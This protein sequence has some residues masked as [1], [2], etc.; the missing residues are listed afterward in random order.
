MCDMKDPKFLIGV[1]EGFYGRPWT[2]EQRRELFGRLNKHG[3]N[4]FV[5]APK[6]DC[7]HRAFWRELY[8]VE[9]AENLMGLV[10]AAKESKI[11]FYYSLSPGLDITYSSE[12]ELVALKRKLDQVLQFGCNAVALLFD[13]IEPEM[14]KKDKEVFQS[15]AHAQV[16]ITNEIFHH[17]KINKFLFC[18]T[19]YCSSR[20]TPD[21]INSEYLS[22]L[23]SQLDPGIDILWTGTKVI[24]KELTIECIQE[25]A[26]VLKRKPLI[27]DNIFA[28]DYDQKRVFLG[29]YNGRS[30]ELIPLLRGVLANPNCEFNA[31]FIGI[32]TLSHWVHCS[33]DT[34]ISNSISADVKL[35]T[36][37]EDGLYSQDAPNCLSNKI[38]HPRLAL[39]N[40][41][42][43]WISEFFEN[44]EHIGPLVKPHP[45]LTMVVPIPILPSIN[46]CMTMTA[47]TSTTT[48]A[49]SLP[50]V[51][52]TQLHAFAEVCSSISDSF[53]TLA[54]PV[55]MNSLVSA[56][57]V[58]TTDLT[59]PVSI[60][61]HIALPE[62]IPISSL[63]P[64]SI[65]SGKKDNFESNA[66]E[67]T[68]NLQ[69]D[70]EFKEIK[71][72]SIKLKEGQLHDEAKNDFFTDFEPMEQ[73]N[74]SSSKD[75]LKILNDDIH[76]HEVSQASLKDNQDKTNITRIG[77][78]K[79]K[80]IDE[81]ENQITSD[82][83]LL[84]C[85]LFYLPFEH[86][87]NALHL[88]NE[89]Q[90]LKMNSHILIRAKEKCKNSD[91]KSDNESEA[92]E[93]IR[94][95]KAFKMLCQSIH[96][97]TKKISV[98]KNRELCYDLY[99]YV[100]EIASVTSLLSA[101][102]QWLSL[103]KFPTNI[104]DYTQGSY[105]YFSKGWKEAFT[106]GC[107]EPWVFRGGLIADLQRLIPIDSANDLFNY[108]LPEKPLSTFYKIRV[109]E[110]T[111]EK[112][113]YSICHKCC[114]DGSDCSILFPQGVTESI[115]ADRLVGPFLTLN[116]EFCIVIENEERIIG[117]ACA[118]LDAKVFYRNQEIAWIPE[119]CLK[120]PLSM[121]N[122]T[123]ISKVARET[124]KHFHNFKFDF[125]QKVLS[126]HGSIISCCVL[127]DQLLI[128]QNIPKR[129]M[130][131]LLA[132]LRSNGSFGG[133]SCI[134]RS[135]NFL[136]DFYSK[137]GFTEL[138]SE[139]SKK[140]ASLLFQVL[141]IQ[142]WSF[143]KFR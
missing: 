24:T 69:D 87:L 106:S 92:Q 19:Q 74:I 44:K 111:D 18:P 15:F 101:Y 125:P 99:T 57:K 94:R 46:T 72:S 129:L 108:K 7:K 130:T 122:E 31:N 62:K 137:I 65:I 79:E 102:V 35:E 37:I 9:E 143:Q 53:P 116:P 140:H 83:I 21:V 63:P 51:N 133:F 107:N 32:S 118:A 113:V 59:V 103:A 134:N 40:A 29:P 13:D 75:S 109:Y 88:L 90:W 61:N 56:S 91:H 97:L 96:D 41:I 38:Y 95:A 23:G 34:K 2:T 110:N 80:F 58:V 39:K 112:D 81:T 45:P 14:S 20:A 30:P 78:N 11:D 12:K 48:M 119:M 5:Y 36:E 50:E 115:P 66:T 28:N 60:V 3:M 132:C 17:L 117:Y 121:L 33:S 86:G 76:M 142:K 123:N 22:T 25:I 82:D 10:A 68:T 128:D 85:D 127:K 139:D 49:T 4:S 71:L 42:K 6:D 54:S 93:W 138:L 73:E 67:Y 47:S 105:T 124:I 98:C 100:W 120:Y 55:V 52:T 77:L 16:S 141:K 89:F 135:D 64:A 27:W 43:D 26:E 114:L 1:V 136:Y 104:Q 126:A 131:V 84:L 8:T 70:V